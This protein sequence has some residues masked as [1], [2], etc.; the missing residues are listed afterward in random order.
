[1]REQQKPILMTDDL[2]S[3]T[4]DG[5]KRSQ[6]IKS[7]ATALAKK[8][9]RSLKLIHVEDLTMYPVS[10]QIYQEFIDNWV[11]ERKSS[12]NK[13][14][15]SLNVPVH[16]ELLEGYPAQKI[17]ELTSKKSK[18]EFVILGSH[19][20]K[21]VKRLVL[22]SVAEEVIRNSQI[23]VFTLGPNAIE[24]KKPL[25][26]GSP[27]RILVATDLSENGRN[28]ENYALSLAKQLKA[29]VILFH[30]LFGGFH[31]APIFSPGGTLIELWDIDENFRSKIAEDLSQKAKKFQKNKILCKTHLDSRSISAS[32]AILKEIKKQNPDFVV[33][34][35]H[36]RNLISGAFFGNTAREIILSSPVP[37]L[38]IR[39]R[40]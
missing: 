15:K 18:F 34:G 35:T 20:R 32:S 8:L 10:Q 24:S 4:T 11:S 5:K 3:E 22:G 7:W 38:T 23:P 29:E 1:M 6:A 17:I 37:V 40:D 33:M 2:A 27:I 28:A 9:H 13:M 26:Q 16:Y 39:S 30:S 19:G 36:G 14:S 31:P 25:H 21:G 12:L